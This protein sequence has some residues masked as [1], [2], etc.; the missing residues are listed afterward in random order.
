MSH[1]LTF[2][3]L[4]DCYLQQKHKKYERE[5]IGNFH[6]GYVGSAVWSETILKS[7][8]GMYQIYSGTSSI[9]YWDSFFDVPA[10]QYDIQRGINKYNAEH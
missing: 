10:D 4:A 9:R 1:A 2:Q 3:L 7:M 6:Y 5:E 8:A